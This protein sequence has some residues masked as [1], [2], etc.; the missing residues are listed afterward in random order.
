MPKEKEMKYVESKWFVI[1]FSILFGLSSILYGITLRLGDKKADKEEVTRIES[2]V[3][4]NCDKID[5]TKD[6]IHANTVVLG[7]VETL[8]E[9]LENK[10]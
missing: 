9:S 7:K 5:E 8:L 1:G 3:D 6:L 2:R 10:K 4:R